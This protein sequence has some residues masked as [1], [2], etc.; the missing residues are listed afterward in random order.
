MKHQLDAPIV[1]QWDIKK[2]SKGKNTFWYGFKERL[3]ASTKSQYIVG[4]LTS[5]NL[6][7]GK[8]TNPLFKKSKS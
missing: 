1:R 4:R 3:A 2:I 5:G 8:T 6:H 7:D